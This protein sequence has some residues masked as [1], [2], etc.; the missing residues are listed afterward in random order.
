MRWEVD[1]ATI[2]EAEQMR[3]IALKPGGAD[4][5]HSVKFRNLNLDLPQMMTI[6]AGLSL[7]THEIIDKKTPFILAAGVLAIVGPLLTEMKVEI[8]QQEATVFWGMIQTTGTMAGAG[9]HEPTIREATNAERAKYRLEPLTEAQ[10]RASLAKL[11]ALKSV[12]Q[13]GDAYRIVETF[14]V[15]A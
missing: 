10:V 5:G 7:T 8:A 15:K 14:T 3:G 1:A 13:A 11:V 12:A 4:G 6:S 2:P 9:L